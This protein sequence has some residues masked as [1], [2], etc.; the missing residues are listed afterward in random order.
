MVNVVTYQ[1]TT[2]V[3]PPARFE[4]GTPAIVQAIGLGTALEYMMNLGMDNIKAHEDELVDYMHSRLPEIKGL[5]EIGTGSR[6][7]RRVFLLCRRNSSAGFG[8]Y[9]G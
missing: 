9:S 5:H 4:A 6:Q 3:V 1:T 2:F 8:L 7:G